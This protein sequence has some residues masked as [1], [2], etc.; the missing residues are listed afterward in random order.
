MDISRDRS[1]I[2]FISNFRGI[3]YPLK[4][5]QYGNEEPGLEGGAAQD[6]RTVEK[7]NS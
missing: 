2:W 5:G 6:S 7:L 1:K 4:K 3:F